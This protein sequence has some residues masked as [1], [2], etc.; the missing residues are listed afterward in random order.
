MSGAL[1]MRLSER[2]VD[3]SSYGPYV[4]S[5][6]PG[7]ILSAL[8]PG[9]PA[10]MLPDDAL[11]GLSNKYD[12][13]VLF[14]MDGF[15]WG[16]FEEIKKKDPFVKAL[17]GRGNA[18]RL[19]TQFPSTTACNVTTMNTGLSVAQH[20]VYEWF[21]YEPKVGEIIAPLLYSYGRHVK[22]RDSLKADKG[23]QPADIYPGQSIYKKLIGHGV[24]CHAFQD[25]EYAYSPYT[26]TVFDGAHRYGYITPSD[27][28]IN[29]A[30][31]II[32]EP[33]KAYYY[34]Y[35]DKLDS[36]SHVYGPGSKEVNAEAEAF[37]LSLERIFWDKVK[38]K[39]DRTLFILTADHGQAAIRPDR[40][41]YL[42]LAFPE[43]KEWIKRSKSGRY[44]V[45]AGSCR[46]MFLYIKEGCLDD[47]FHFL[48]DKLHDKALVIKTKDLV[49]NGYFGERYV[50]EALGGRLG[51][52][53]ILP[54]EGQCV[55]WYEKEL[56]EIKFL[57]HH[58]GLT[59]QEMEIPFLAWDV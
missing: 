6:I 51:N 21:Y 33:G 29:L 59:K 44:L 42:N 13:V 10:R 49:E 41:V 12:K 26:D 50:S 32:D 8:T 14:L 22:E 24:S 35:L 48:A 7:T 19:G 46:D 9:T 37:F 30:E 1:I 53:V 23:V 58:G 47:A 11:S 39:V 16:H 43:V 55:W 52:L 17:C 54:F 4:L 36:L 38:D 5:G 56:F 40:C 45:P 31:R 28:L 27:G 3:P 2:F 57:G 20:G 34:F 15:G 18:M 25:I